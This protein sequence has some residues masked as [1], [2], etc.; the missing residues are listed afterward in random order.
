MKD[1]VKITA[2]SVGPQSSWWLKKKKKEYRGQENEGIVS[3]L[4][5]THDSHTL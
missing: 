3:S 5:S 1:L 4:L 2:M